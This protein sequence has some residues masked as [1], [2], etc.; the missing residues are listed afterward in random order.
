MDNWP[1]SLPRPQV[2][3]C[4]YTPQ[5]NQIRTEMRA[6]VPKVRRATTAR[7]VDVT[8]QLVLTQAQVQTLDDFVAIT[9]S[10]VLPFQWMDFRRPD[11]EENVAVYRFTRRPRYAPRRSGMYWTATID[12]EL[13]TTLQGTYLL[14]IE[15]LST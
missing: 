7:P 12:L 10:D 11:G 9:L 2:D 8:F 6:G 13:M 3:G 15:G 14:D 1:S 5:D 4:T